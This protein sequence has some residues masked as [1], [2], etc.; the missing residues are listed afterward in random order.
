MR[1]TFFGIAAILF[2]TSNCYAEDYGSVCRELEAKLNNPDAS[3]NV[4]M[5]V[6]IRK[7]GILKMYG[8]PELHCKLR[9]RPVKRGEKFSVYGDYE[10]WKKIQ[11]EDDIETVL[12]WI[13]KSDFDEMFVVRK[14]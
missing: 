4:K 14:P 12:T 8:S 1:I 2:L 5:R 10:G 11:Y 3:S 9:K 13:S 6:A 7:D